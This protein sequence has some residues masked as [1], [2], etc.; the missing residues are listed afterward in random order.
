M[1]IQHIYFTVF[2]ASILTYKALERA[3][4][5]DVSQHVSEFLATLILS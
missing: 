3:F 1:T 5:P 4:L 2:F